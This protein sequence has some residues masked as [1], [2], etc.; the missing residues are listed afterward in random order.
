MLLFLRSD[1]MHGGANS[2]MIDQRVYKKRSICSPHPNFR[3][4]HDSTQ[5]YIALMMSKWIS[6]KP[7]FDPNETYFSANFQNG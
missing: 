4:R 7:T 1:W 5:I 2:I 6:G 3:E